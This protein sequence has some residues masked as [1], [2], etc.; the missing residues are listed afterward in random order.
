MKRSIVTC[1]CLGVGLLVPIL[2]TQVYGQ[3]TGPLPSPATIPDAAAKE[4]LDRHRPELLKK[5]GVTAVVPVPIAGKIYMH[6]VVFTNA[7][8]ERPTVLP[9][10]IAAL[11]KKI[12]GVPVELVIEYALPPPPGVTILKPGGKRESADRCPPEYQETM[13][14]GWRFC[15][16][17]SNPEPIPAIMFPP[18]PPIAGI[19]YEEALKILDRRTDLALIPGV[20][21]IRLGDDSLIIETSG[22][23]AILPKEV[24]GLPVKIQIRPSGFPRTNSHRINEPP[25]RPLMGA[26][27]ISVDPTSVYRTTTLHLGG[28]SC[29]LWLIFPAHVLTGDQCTR[30]SPCTQPLEQ[31]LNRYKS[32]PAYNDITMRQPFFNAQIGQVVKWTPIGTNEA[33]HDVAAAWM[34]NDMN[35]GNSSLCMSPSVDNWGSITGQEIAPAMITTSMTLYVV[36]SRETQQIHAIPVQPITVNVNQNVL[37]ICRSD[38][39]STHLA[40]NQIYY[41]SLLGQ[42]FAA[43]D[44]GAPVLTGSGEI[45]GMHNWGWDS[46]PPSD[47]RYATGGG[48]LALYIRDSLG[49]SKWYGTSTFPHHPQICQ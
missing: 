1:L 8:G 6:A 21:S 16:D 2:N 4:I 12:E 43:G 11:P 37:S 19:P 33:S 13:E 7:K 44:S 32:V 18:R 38:P 24:D 14:Q 40:R 34:D 27:P 36:S 3:G 39:G 46:L 47:P 9:Q 42:P 30:P 23:P 49:F 10:H 20:I 35:Q 5:P 41:R 48:T 28:F 45:V 17:P 31:C 29:G 22:D 15:I 25:V 26:L